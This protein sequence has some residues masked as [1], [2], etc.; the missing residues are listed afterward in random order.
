MSDNSTPRI[1][2]AEAIAGLRAELLRAREDSKGSD[3]RFGVS[4]VD[5]ELTLDFGW[6]RDANAGVKL[7]SF[8]DIGGKA[9]DSGRTGSATRE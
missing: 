1:G 3:I 9:G 8:L 2:L 6:T 7:F 5:V 4:T